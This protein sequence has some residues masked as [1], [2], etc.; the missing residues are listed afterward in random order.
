[1]AAADSHAAAQA[2]LAAAEARFASN[3]PLSKAQHDLATSSLPGG[4]TRT[5]LH[6]P[7]FPLT[8]SHGQGTS[9][10]DLDGHK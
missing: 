9:L 5:L 4:N 6:T 2:A 1:M 8:M 7:P 3:N 10:F